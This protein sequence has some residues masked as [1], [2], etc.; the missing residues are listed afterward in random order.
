MRIFIVIFFV[1]FNQVRGYAQRAVLDFTSSNLPIILIDTQGK[2]IPYD[3]PR[4]SAEMGIIYNGQGIRNNLTDPRNNCSGKISIEIRGSSSAGWA[5]KS[6]GIETQHDDGTNRNVSLLGFPEDN[7][8]V[9]YGPYYDRSLLRNVLVMKLVHDMGWYASR[10]KF[11]ELVLNGKYQGIYVLME[12]IKRGKNRVDIAKLTQQEV[13]GDDVTGGY[14]IKIDKEPWKPGFTSKYRPFAGAW[15]T[16]RY[17]Y[18]YPDPDEITINQQNYIKN[19]VDQFEAIMA[20][21]KFADATI[22]YPKYLNVESFIDYFLINEL[23]RNVDAYRLS[24]YFYKDKDSNGGKLCAGPVWDYNFSFGNAGYYNSYI[25][26]D[27]QL[28]YFNED[29]DFKQGDYWQV[30]FWWIKLVN[31]SQFAQRLTSRWHELRNNV[32]DINKV[33]QYLDAI[34]DTLNEAQQ[35]NFEIWIGPGEPKLPTDEWFPPTFPIDHLRTYQDEI[36]YLKFWLANRIYWMDLHLDDFTSVAL[37]SCR[38]F[39]TTFL[40]EQNYPNPFNSAAVIGYQLSEAGW[41]ELSIV[42]VLGKKVKVLVNGLVSAGKHQATWNGSDDR[43]K[44]VDS[45]IYFCQ[46]ILNNRLSQCKKMTLLK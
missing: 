40:L 16:I 42:D 13:A 46:L 26:T 34:A 1:L 19:F 44:R 3:D 38:I 5:K 35:R 6:Y 17:Q 2:E 12:K 11:C 36:E 14:I 41:I 24:A 21:S 28:N 32:L 30:P 8:W 43:E 15:Q 20:T 18:H 37:R 7:D 27:W 4:L 9:L 39:P 45:G 31:E 10:T 29:R 23:S 25:V 33:H 22:G